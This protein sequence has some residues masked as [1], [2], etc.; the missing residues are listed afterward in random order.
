MG[1][2]EEELRRMF[3]WYTED[4]DDI[5]EGVQKSIADVDTK[6]GDEIEDIRNILKGI[7]NSPEL[8]SGI[9]TE[10]NISQYIPQNII[11][12]GNLWN[13]ITIDT[14]LSGDSANPV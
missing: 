7:G 11:T 12:E 4:F 2:S 5:I 8:P 3:T 9:I 10:E 14:E 13:Y 1:I 6:Y